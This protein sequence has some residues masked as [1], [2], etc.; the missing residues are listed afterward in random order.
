MI[1]NYQLHDTNTWSPIAQCYDKWGLDTWVD[2]P[3]FTSLRE[4][5]LQMVDNEP[6]E[7]PEF[8]ED[9]PS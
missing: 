9:N 1:M 3:V 4:T 5:F 6:A 2:S 7:Y 8:D